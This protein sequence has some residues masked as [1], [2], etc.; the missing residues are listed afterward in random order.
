MRFY[1]LRVTFENIPFLFRE[2][3]IMK[4]TFSYFPGIF[5]IQAM[6]PVANEI[7]TYTKTKLNVF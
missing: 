3:L 7:L 4:T 5:E 1:D 6:K 2:F